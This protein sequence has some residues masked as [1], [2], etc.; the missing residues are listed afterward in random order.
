MTLISFYDGYEGK[1]STSLIYFI[2]DLIL[3]F[4]F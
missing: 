4:K 2:Y 3:E 1:D